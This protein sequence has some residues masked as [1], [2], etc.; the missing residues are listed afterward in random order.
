MKMQKKHEPDSSFTEKLEWQLGTELRRQNRDHAARTS[1][2]RLLGLG[3][4]VMIS[5]VF[6]AGAMA[7]S[8]QMEESWRRELLEA[9]LD[10]RLDLAMRRLDM[11]L[12]ELGRVRE[13]VE[14][15]LIDEREITYFELQIAEAETEAKTL[16][17]EREELRLSG[18]QPVGKVSSPLVDGRDFVSERIHARM[19]L[20]QRH[21]DLMQSEL[22]REIDRF[23]LGL[24]QEQDVL[25]REM[26]VQEAEAALIVL[27]Q[28]LQIRREFVDAEIS[29]VEAELRVL[30]AESE[31][32]ER[33]L[34]QQMEL[35]LLQMER[36]Q[37]EID[38]GLVSPT[39][40][41]QAE[42][43]VAE[44][45]AEL[46]LAQIELQVLRRELDARTERR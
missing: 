46:M 28:E 5:V 11:Q 13:R 16:D 1:P 8:Q 2:R 39:A 45:E 22:D 33:L 10:V 29:A 34:N 4:L 12:E 31:R 41:A 23:Q 36:V 26:A 44:L 7:A 3:A 14:Q 27:Q 42:L 32:K 30:Q 18:R 40:G 15:G 35:V 43:H 19:A 17:L 37:A 25:G 21:L 6:G 20:Q 24:I 38:A 9:S